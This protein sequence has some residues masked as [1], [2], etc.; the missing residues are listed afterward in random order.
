MVC[1]KCQKSL[2]QVGNFWVCPIHGIEN[3][4][5]VTPDR[6][7]SADR[8]RCLDLNRIDR[9][10]IFISYSGTEI[11]LFLKRLATDLREQKGY[12]VWLDFEDIEQKG[13]FE[14]FIEL[15]TQVASMRAARIPF[16]VYEEGSY[17]KGETVWTSSNLKE[18]APLQNHSDTTRPLLLTYRKWIDFTKDYDQGLSALLE[19]L[20]EEE[21]ASYRPARLIT[22][23]TMPLSFDPE[24]TRFS[25]GFI[26]REWLTTELDYRLASDYW[27]VLVII[28]EPGI[29]KSAIA[30]WIGSTR[31]EVAGIYFCS[32]QNVRSL[33]PYEFVTYLVEQLCA[34]VPGF[35][36][37]VEIRY[38]KN[39]RVTAGEAFRELVVEPIWE[40]STN[41]E[42]S[43]SGTWLIVIDALDEAI[44]NTTIYGNKFETVIDILTQQAQDLPVWL[45]II[46]TTRPEAKILDQIRS[47]ETFELR[48]D[49]QEN[50]EDVKQYIQTRLY[51]STLSS[52]VGVEVDAL[53]NQLTQLASGNFLCA[54][55]VLDALEEGTLQATDLSKSTLRLANFYWQAFTRRFP[56][57]KDYTQNY[58]DILQILSAARGPLPI[59]LLQKMCGMEVQVVH[60]ALREL[61]VYLHISHRVEYSSGDG[62]KAYELFHKSLQKWLTDPDLAGDYGCS[63]MKG[64]TRIAE[65]LLGEGWKN[66][67]ALCYL[68]THLILMKA[69]EQL[70]ELLCNLEFIESKCAAGLT[71]ELVADYN[72]ALAVWREYERKA[73]GENQ[74][75]ISTT[76]LEQI[77]GLVE[78][79]ESRRQKADSLLPPAFYPVIPAV[80][81]DWLRM[82]TV[83]TLVGEPDPRP[84]KG[85]GPV[86]SSL[87]ALPD[88]QRH[89]DPQQPRYTLGERIPDDLF[90]PD[91]GA[92]MTL[93]EVLRMEDALTAGIDPYIV[94]E[95][96]GLL[97]TFAGFVFLHSHLLET[98]PHEAIPLAYN[99]AARGPVVQQAS[100]LVEVL[101]HPWVAR[102][103]RPPRLPTRP[104][105]L[106]TFQGHTSWVNSVAL[107]L[108]NQAVVSASRD[109]TLRVWDIATGQCLAILGK[110]WNDD[111]DLG[112]TSSVTS[113]ALPLDSKIIISAS[114]DKTLRIWDFITGECIQVLQ[115]HMGEITSVAL[116]SDGK[117]AVSASLDKTLCIWDITARQCIHILQGH[118]GW[119]TGVALAPDGKIAVSSSRDHTL[120]V[121]DVA[122]GQCLRVMQGHPSSVTSVALTSNGK[123][124]ISASLDNAL[125]A[126]DITTG[127]HLR[128]MNGHTGRVTSVAI[129][130]D[131]KIAVSA[132]WDNT[133]RVWDVTSGEC[134]RTLYRHIDWIRGVTIS[135]D[136]KIAIS[137]SSDQTLRVWDIASGTYLQTLQGHDA[138][139]TDIALTANGK[140][141]ISASRDHTLGIW[142]VDSGQCLRTLQ[143]HTDWVTGVAIAPDDKLAVS[144][145]RDRTLKI[146]N[147]VTGQ[148][149]RTLRG[150]I[151]WVTNV[152]LTPDGK[153]IISV[154]A[155]N[156]LRIWSVRTG[157]CLRVLSGQI[158][159]I[160]NVTLTPDGKT[161]IAACS[162]HTLRILDITSGKCLRS[163]GKEWN[164][165]PQIGH[166]NWVTRVALAS[167]GESVISASLDKTLRVWN[168]I[169]G[170]CLKI[171]QGHS[172][173]VLSVSLTSNGK[174]AISASADNT[175]R[176][177]NLTSGECLTVYHAGAPVWSV[178][179]VRSDGRFVC[180]TTDGQMH[181]LTL[182]NLK[183]PE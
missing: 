34:R 130:P 149:S 178:S 131:G 168:F 105:H 96:P 173:E 45:R 82:C 121:W 100:I 125:H 162:D 32:H 53:I 48:A 57:T 14:V 133:L 42:S 145:S 124:A 23:E 68:P 103:P 110:E 74:K 28:G 115:G 40:L 160:T 73:D 2:T 152:V 65:T 77:L 43:G 181:F 67:Y 95:T 151:N 36:K 58:V 108:N 159:E 8:A 59:S 146:W 154:G 60:R 31:S 142:D 134:L 139:I 55:L 39:R 5:E 107:A 41:V 10:Q 137:A 97:E 123:M 143:G 183:I 24:I 70:D 112:H 81:P 56:N 17:Q 135:P 71:Y 21:P 177:W 166:T 90:G 63:L 79:A 182:R 129:T 89:L 88:K 50:Y 174:A 20:V 4:R 180:G 16:L 93:E 167:N 104:I 109:H 163:L 140:T 6:T 148:C 155:D 158:S 86:L 102:E 75:S 15:D 99:H 136:G 119:V 30:T 61:Q 114:M 22:P 171:L 147:V 38:P 156:T 157:E 25:S 78:R 111:P 44:Y 19:Y 161:I 92:K 11:L 76:S 62:M 80:T 172:S 176:V 175:L 141:A 27:R 52:R 35:A 126:W 49:Q 1:F 33:D 179:E 47:F 72:I 13:L 3:T 7:E 87:R 66:D 46:A 69:W 164:D 54:R 37:R 18:G 12:K 128:I 138:R 117:I 116:T 150:H 85:A 153:T 101:E 29:G 165:N 118:T 26:G 113:I 9:K 106:R 64:H 94:D 51:S 83:A 98:A 122:T 120:R 144:A 127:E 84:D 132:S 91:E 169:S 170:K